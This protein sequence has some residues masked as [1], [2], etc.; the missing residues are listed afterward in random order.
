MQFRAGKIVDGVERSDALCGNKTA[1]V[2]ALWGLAPSHSEA[3]WDGEDALAVVD[4]AVE[5]A[6]E[7]IRALPNG[8]D[9]PEIGA[10]PDGSIALEWISSRRRMR[11]VGVVG[12]SDRLAYA[13]I[14]G[15]DRGH[16]TAR[17]AA[18]MVP[19]RLLHAI[20]AITAA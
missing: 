3:G 11:S 13:W 15:T 14:D 4:R 20:R 1:I 5:R 7:F 17:F 18:G 10:D 16:A 9:M 8:C 12:N 2:S 6:V 19:G